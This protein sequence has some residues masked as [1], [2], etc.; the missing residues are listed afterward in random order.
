[1]ASTSALFRPLHPRS[2]AAV[3]FCRLLMNRIRKLRKVRAQWSAAAVSDDWEIDD[4]D[5]KCV[6]PV[7]APTST[8]IIGMYLISKCVGPD[9]RQT[10]AHH[11][12]WNSAPHERELLH[13]TALLFRDRV[14]TDVE[15]Q[16]IVLGRSTFTFGLV[17]QGIKGDVQPVVRPWM[18]HETVKLQRAVSLL[19]LS[20]V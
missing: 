8:C 18:M 11:W 4:A 9:V 13:T 5:V 19:S 6:T 2:C 14:A 3:I 20:V 16:D 15:G 10:S 12:P 17:L 7:T 1:M